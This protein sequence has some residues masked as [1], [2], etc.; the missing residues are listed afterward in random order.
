MLEKKV[1]WAA[2]YPFDRDAINYFKSVAL[3]IK[4][5]VTEYKDVIEYAYN[6]ALN[7]LRGRINLDWDNDYVEGI[8]FYLAALIIAGTNNFYLYKRFSDIEAKRA[9]KILQRESIENILRLSNNLDLNISSGDE[10]INIFYIDFIRLTKGISSIHWRLYNFRLHKGYVNLHKKA[11]ARLLTEV[12]KN[13]IYDIVSSIREIPE[14]IVFYS[15][16]IMDNVTIPRKEPDEIIEL[17][18]RKKAALFPPCVKYLLENVKQGLSHPGRFTLVTFLHR[19]GYDVDEI[20]NVFK[21][22]PDFNERMTRYQVE[23]ITG[24]RGSRIEYNIPSCKKIRSYGYC[25]PD[26]IC[27][28]YNIR[29]PLKYIK[30]K[31][32]LLSHEA[33]G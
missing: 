29:H 20:V 4:D 6:R 30:I 32:R 3:P 14:E 7:S 9:Y 5:Y 15:N 19:I 16:K 27:K 1:R 28:K 17:K 13:K 24:M 23:H 12:I 18:D 11:F 10:V 2:K 8:S 22:T 33:E 31:R 25:I 26:E 21:V